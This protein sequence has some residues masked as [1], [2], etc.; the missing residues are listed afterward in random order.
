MTMAADGYDDGGAHGTPPPTSTSHDDPMDDAHEGKKIKFER[1]LRAEITITRG[2]RDTP[3]LAKPNVRSLVDAIS[4]TNPGITFKIKDGDDTF[5]NIDDFPKGDK[6]QH[7]FPMTTIDSTP[8]APQKVSVEICVESTTVIDFYKRTEGK[9]YNYLDQNKIWITEHHFRTLK[10]EKIG[11]L[12]NISTVW[13]LQ[14]NA[15]SNLIQQIDKHEDHMREMGSTELTEPTPRFELW[16]RNVKGSKVE[17]SKRPLEARCYEVTCE[18]IHANTLRAKLTDSQPKEAR[19]GIFIQH[20]V[21]VTEKKLHDA[22]INSHNHYLDNLRKIEILGISREGMDSVNANTGDSGK[23][24][25]RDLLMRLHDEDSNE[26][27]LQSIEPTKDTDETG[28]WY[29]TC[30]A[31]KEK[32]N[33]ECIQG[34]FSDLREQD[35][36]LFP[37][38]S[39]G[40]QQ[41][42]EYEAYKTALRNLVPESPASNNNGGRNRRSRNNGNRNRN[43]RSS[44]TIAYDEETFPELSTPKQAPL[45]QPSRTTP[46]RAS[47]TSTPVDV[48]RKKDTYAARTAAPRSSKSTTKAANKTRS[49]VSDKDR[50]TVSNKDRS[51][52]TTVPKQYSRDEDALLKRMAECDARMATMMSEQDARFAA[53]ESRFIEQKGITTRMESTSKEE[54]QRLNGLIQL[55]ISIVQPESTASTD[56]I[57]VANDT[58]Q[59][60]HSKRGLES[61]PSPNNGATKHLNKRISRPEPKQ[62][63]GDFED[64]EIHAAITEDDEDSQGMEGMEQTYTQ[65]RS[66]SPSFETAN[67]SMEGSEAGEMNTQPG[68]QES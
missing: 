26:P 61:S 37:N 28:K 63:D 2:K 51:D 66:N 10:T 68:S 44:V 52:E 40:G 9:L 19:H 25:L 38:P 55:L 1:S 12:S 4:Q 57:D 62:L 3:F 23:S 45:S 7:F 16:P 5:K 67:S 8:Q 30:K 6:F 47:Q 65:S 32:L 35:P 41:K 20:S 29:L 27:S 49:T 43:H 64:D 14:K 24:S 17:G 53:I 46:I 59:V 36:V 15:E 18:A 22:I 48:P 56:V 39:I 11:F 31:D 33:L 34:L 50:S 60:V 58:A 54:Y 13:A 21:R 42:Y